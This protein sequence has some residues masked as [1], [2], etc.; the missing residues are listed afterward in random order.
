MKDNSSQI[1]TTRRYSMSQETKT[2]KDKMFTSGRDTVVLTRD[3]RLS[4]LTRLKRK[5]LLD[6]M[7][8]TDSI[9]TD[10]SISDQDSQ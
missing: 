1:S 2:E 3:G 8:A 9:S 4:T 7:E 10:N 6:I 5:K